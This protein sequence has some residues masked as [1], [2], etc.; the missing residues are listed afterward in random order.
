MRLQTKPHRLLWPILAAALVASWSSGFVGIRYASEQAD[1]MLVLFWRT[2]IS[3]LILLPFAVLI[4][5]Q[6]SARAM[7]QQMGFGVAVM[8][9]FSNSMREV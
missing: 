1:V 2:L 6:I 8:F 9:L 3:G 4:G 5:P 7:I